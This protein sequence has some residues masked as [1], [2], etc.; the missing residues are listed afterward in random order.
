MLLAGAT[1]WSAL[2]IPLAFLLPVESAPYSPLDPSSLSIGAMES[3]VTV[4]GRRIL[5]VV[6]IPLHRV[7]H[8]Y[9]VAHH[10]AAVS[11]G[12][13]RA[14]LRGSVS[15]GL[16]AALPYIR[17][18]WDSVVVVKYGG[19]ALAGASPAPTMGAARSPRHW[20][21]SPRTSC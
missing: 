2:L 8:H 6:V 7:A 3:L 4:N 18:F 12:T 15:I 20:R 11:V 14:G 17:K 10:E 19:N 5:L 13:S 21:R 9:R 16:L 1:A